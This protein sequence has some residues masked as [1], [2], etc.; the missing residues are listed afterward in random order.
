MARERRLNLTSSALSG[1]TEILGGVGGR[2]RGGKSLDEAVKE[3][4]FLTS[5]EADVLIEGLRAGGFFERRKW[6]SRNGRWVSVE[7]E[8]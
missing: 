1:V 8:L 5:K 6:D 4:P 2:R 3:A 7:C